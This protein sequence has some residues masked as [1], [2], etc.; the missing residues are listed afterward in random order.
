[1]AKALNTPFE[2]SG[3]AHLPQ[4]A[5]RRSTVQ[6]VAQGL[7]AITA[8][9]LE[10]PAPSVAFRVEAI[11]TLFGHGARLD[12]D[13]SSA[14][15]E[16]V[17]EV[18]RLLPPDGRVL[19]RLCPTPSAAA[20]VAADIRTHIASAETVFDWGGG[21]VWLSLDVREAG[22]D[23]GAGVIRAAIK[24]RGGHATLIVAPEA[25]RGRVAVFE[26]EEPALGAL[27]S[28]IKAQFDP[29]GVLNPGRMG[30]GR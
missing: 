14:F 28:R 21:L 1:M 16:E 19:W 30:E 2:V 27:T 3:V 23:A 9:R 22:P 8:I 7:G 6:D 18:H 10:G 25:T 12:D 15:W 24:P 17:G 5:A 26:P 4:P 29:F 13:A 11:E 20:A